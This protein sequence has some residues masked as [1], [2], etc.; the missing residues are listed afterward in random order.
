MGLEPKTQDELYKD[1]WFPMEQSFGHSERSPQFD[2]L[3][4]DYLTIKNSGNIPRIDEV[5][6]EFKNHVRRLK[7][8]NIRNI[9]ADIYRY[10][11]YFVNLAF[12]KEE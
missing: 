2:R 9:V 4:R 8:E 3:I 10:S 12:L 7:G 11:K 6:V 5:Y 1:Y